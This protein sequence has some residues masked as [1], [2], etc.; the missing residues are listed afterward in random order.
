MKKPFIAYDNENTTT[1]GALAYSEYEILVGRNW[2]GINPA[3]PILPQLRGM[4]AYRLI[5]TYGD[6]KYS[7]INPSYE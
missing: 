1:M 5:G 2:Y 4:R 7:T 3:E 6:M